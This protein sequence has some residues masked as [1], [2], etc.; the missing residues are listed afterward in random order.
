[1][2]SQLEALRAYCT[3]NDLRPAGVYNDAGISARKRYTRRPELLRLLD[4]CRAGKIDVV[5]F[6]KLDRWFR[7]VGDYYE[8]QRQLD[9]CGVPWRAI[10]EDYETETSA[11]VFKVNIMLSVAQSEADRT[12]ERIRDVMAY[13]RERGDYVGKAPFGY[14]KKGRELLIDENLQQGV[15]EFFRSF[16][17]SYNIT[18]AMRDAAVYGFRTHRETAIKVL[19][20]PAYAGACRN[21]YKCPAYITPEQHA[22]ICEIHAQ[23]IREPKERGRVYLFSGLLIC[24]ECGAHLGGRTRVRPRV[25]GSFERT[26]YYNCNGA[27]GTFHPHRHLHVRECVIEV[28]LLDNLAPLLNGFRADVEARN[29]AA[30][31]DTAEAQKAAL[32]ARLRRVQAVYMDGG[33]T[34][35]EYAARRDSINEEIAGITSEPLPVPAELP[36]GWRAVYDDLDRQHKRTFWHSVIKSISVPLDKSTFHVAFR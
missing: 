15:A 25:D 36:A 31:K 12:S 34:D 16:L 35:A 5:L 6:T 11:G 29:R 17:S 33:M 32:R 8:V 27:S 9:A 3:E 20:N 7:S 26:V 30:D 2:D 4:D 23:R 28:F 14:V 21:G 1:M 22:L 19:L 24:A 10:W 13:K 18:A